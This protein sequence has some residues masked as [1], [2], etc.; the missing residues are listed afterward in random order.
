MKF[1]L[2]SFVFATVFNGSLRADP[3]LTSWYT[4]DSGRYARLFTST[5]NET[6]GTAVTTWSRGAGTENAPAYSGVQ[7]ISYSDTYVYIRTTGLASH[8]MGPWY[9]DAAKTQNFP[10]FPGHTNTIYRIPRNPSPA[11]TKTATGLGASGFYV[12]GVAMFDMRDAFS[13]RN[14]SAQDATPVNGLT[15]DGVWNREAY[16]NEGVTFDA[17]LAHQAGEQY[18]YHA[19]P[20]ALRWQLGD[21]VDCNAATNRY[22]ESTSPV[23]K[24][25]P[26]L[27]W[28]AD[29]YP[30]YGPYGYASA[31]DPA[32]GPRRMTSGFV[33]RD[34]QNGTVS[35]ANTGRTTLP[36]WA[37]RVQ[38]RATALAANLQGPAVNATYAAGHYLEDYEY[39]GDLGKTQGVDFDLNEQN[40]RW[41]VTPEFPQG[42][43][44]YFCTITAAGVPVFPYSTGRQYYGAAGGGTVQSITEAVTSFWKG[45]P[46]VAVEVTGIS[47]NAANGAMTPVWNSVEGGTYKLETSANLSG[48]TDLT[49]NIA[50]G[51]T[52]TSATDNTASLAARRFYRVTRTALANYDST[53]NGG[54]GTGGGGGA[55]IVSV[56]PASGARGTPFTL[57]VNLDAAATPPLPPQMVAPASVSIGTT[58][59]TNRVHVTQTQV[60]ASFTISVNAATGAQTVTVTFTT[61]NGTN[62]YTLTSGFTVQ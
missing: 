42:T 39:L 38:G 22:T 56:S 24:H 7:E 1:A 10:N 6:A 15:G 27:A 52:S 59:G 26:I 43:W 40:A 20:P 5:A 58:A 60:T 51:G 48:W 35:L 8:V 4:K 31:L 14:A 57:T 9:L 18:H 17:G 33:L 55:G 41:C 29:G 36:A 46:D 49:T 61:P 45:G 23:T 53:G 21:H 28:A 25:S 50:S 13:Y 12:N 54:T 37:G 47:R 16:H 3:H 2:T 32:S 44:A 11:G 30:V 34:G 19:Q 62:T